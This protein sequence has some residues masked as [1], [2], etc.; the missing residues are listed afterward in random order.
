MDATKLLERC[1]ETVDAGEKALE[2]FSRNDQ[3]I[4]HE[5]VQLN[6]SFRWNVMAARRMRAAVERPMCVGV[7]GASQAGKSYLIS[8]LAR[9]GTNPLTTMLGGRKMDY[10]QEI[11]PEGGKEATGLV[12][13]F[14]VRDVPALPDA[15]VS[16]RLLTETD[17]IKILGN[18]YLADVDHGNVEPPNGEQIAQRLDALRAKAKPAP[19]DRLTE[20]DVFDLQHY[21]DRS[22]SAIDRIRSLEVSYWEAAAELAPRLE[23]GE[24]AQLFALLWDDLEPFSELYVRLYGALARLD[25]ATEGCCSLEGLEPRSQ[26]II[27]VD[28]LHGLGRPEAAGKVTL[29]SLSGQSATV[30]RA[31]ATALI[32]ELAVKIDEQPWDFFEHTDL[33]D[34][35]GARSR[36]SIRDIHEYLKDPDR[37]WVFFLRGK[38]A[39]LYERYCADQELTSM[40]LCVGPSNQEVVELT[41]MVK[42]WIDATHGEKPEDR[43]RQDT[44]LFLVLTKFDMEFGSKRGSDDNDMGARWTTRLDASFLHFFGKQDRWPYHWNGKD[45]PFTNIFWVRNPNVRDDSLLDYDADDFELGIRE[46]AKARIEALRKGYLQNE[47]VRTYVG[48]AEA[49]WDAAMEL[50]DGGIG[51]LAERLR[52]V[53][54][55]ELKLRQIEG[56][57]GDL[58]ERIGQR[59]KPYYVS[60]D[61]E[62]EKLKRRKELEEKV[63]PWLVDCM[64]AT[65]F[66]VLQRSLMVGAKEM[67]RVFKQIRFRSS[68]PRV[69]EAGSPAPTPERPKPRLGMSLRDRVRPGSAAAAAP[70]EAVPAESDNGRVEAGG[71]AV[72]DAASVF[73]DAVMQSWS[74]QMRA[75]AQDP[76][77]CR[78]FLFDEAGLDTLI[79]ELL[80]GAERSAMA[81]ELAEGVRDWTRLSI[82][83]HQAAPGAG[84]IAANA[85]NGYLRQLGFERRPEAKRPQVESE[86]G[87]RPIFALRQEGDTLQLSETSGTF[88]IDY[89]VEWIEA[90]R[91]LTEENASGGTDANTPEN[92]KLG[93]I[94]SLLGAAQLHSEA[95][96]NG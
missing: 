54:R 79:S 40:L 17:I 35:P 36:E 42:N 2:W 72:R 94:L 6:R 82:D 20:D 87:P 21:F 63:I 24:R 49:K 39:Y 15:P 60:G 22:F 68:M 76:Q 5:A 58:R 57:L 92:R 31:D 13:R 25:F 91:A 62:A 85:V 52:P 14:T 95:L 64:E 27:N 7:F 51:L 78:Y 53:C 83:P 80:I 81:S 16:L 46:T 69:F 77:R 45:S 43:A 96:T 29:K 47:A 9:K 3:T 55:P 44:A 33:L 30:S 41:S 4:K 28:T 67:E 26:S 32:A 71:S 93:E 12:T 65:R 84:I 19:V 8:A 88:D 70:G 23:I 86:A 50:N 34:F 10:L 59:L 90:V 18:T 89:C 48:D 37:L 75:L 56:R 73:A 11:N 38:V 74:S 66:G 1:D 61:R